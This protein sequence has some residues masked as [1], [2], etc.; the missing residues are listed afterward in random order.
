MTRH[1]RKPAET[2]LSVWQVIELARHQ[3]RPY[4]LDY[5]R[6]LAPDFIELHGDRVFGDDPAL[7]GGI[8]EI[9]GIACVVL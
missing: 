3:D 9:A 2:T 1:G 4:S 6:R 8:G 7:I 5:I